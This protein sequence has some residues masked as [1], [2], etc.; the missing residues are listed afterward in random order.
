MSPHGRSAVRA[1]GLIGRWPRA[2]TG[3][4]MPAKFL[5]FTFL[6]NTR[7][8]HAAAAQQAIIQGR[9]SDGC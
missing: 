7:Y 5:Y 6:I 2:D 3:M 9:S 4:M 1:D 8:E